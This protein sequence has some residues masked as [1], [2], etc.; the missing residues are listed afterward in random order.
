MMHGQKNIKLWTYPVC[1]AIF[2]CCANNILD[3]GV[4]TSSL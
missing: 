2:V 4:Q 3:C 1:Y